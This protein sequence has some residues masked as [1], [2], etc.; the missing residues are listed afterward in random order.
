MGGK[1]CQVYQKKDLISRMR[2]LHYSLGLYPHRTGGLN[3]YATDLMREQ[4]K[5]N[6]VA[7][8]YPG[9]YRFLQSKCLISFPKMVEDIKCYQLVNALPQPLL[10]GIRKPQ[11]FIKKP[12]SRKNFEK[13][14]DSFQPEIL[15]LHTLMGLPEEALK[16]FK[17][18]GVKIVYT[19]HDY[20]GICPKVNLINEKGEL[21]VGLNAERCARCNANAPSTLYLRMRSSS[22]AFKTR[23][24]VRW[25][26]NTINF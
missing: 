3:R 11:D 20:F 4:S 9:N 17:E 5:D 19:S 1:S 6:E 8:L 15:H 24:F 18:K 25:F 7:L 12:I 23:D 21:C 13:F 2:I 22:L 10:F 26:K 16:F 14:Y